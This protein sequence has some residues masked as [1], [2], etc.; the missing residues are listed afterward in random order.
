MEVQHSEISAEPQVTSAANERKS[1]VGSPA[2]H[3]VNDQNSLAASLLRLAEKKI[4]RRIMN[5][6]LAK[7]AR[8]VPGARSVRPWLHRLRGVE[9]EGRVFIGDDVYLENEYPERIR[10]EDGV[11]IGLRSTIVAHTRHCGQVII[12][13]NAFIGPCSVIISAAETSLTIGEGAVVSAGSIITTN[14]PPAIL[15]RPERVK[16]CARVTVPFTYETSY[17]DFCKGLRPV[18]SGRKQ[19]VIPTRST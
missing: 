13:K 10:L 3:A 7:V 17:K 1:V 9:I 19:P 4:V 14:I 2:S 11:Q 6:I 18:G 5:R 16:A 8:N 12:R 15:V